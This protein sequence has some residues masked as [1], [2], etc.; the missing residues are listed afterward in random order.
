MSKDKMTKKELLEKLANLP[1]DAEIHF[2]AWD[3]EEME[4]GR[5]RKYSLCIESIDITTNNDFAH[6]RINGE[7]HYK[8]E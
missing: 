5:I 7:N 6:I 2:S 8:D 1:D 4:N 3:Y